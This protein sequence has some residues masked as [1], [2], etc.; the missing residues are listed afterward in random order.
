MSILFNELARAA[1]LRN[2]KL[3]GDLLDLFA[4]EPLIEWIKDFHYQDLYKIYN[5]VQTI[6]NFRTRIYDLEKNASKYRFNNT[7]MAKLNG[8]KRA[9]N[10]AVIAS[11]LK[12]ILNTNLNKPG[13]PHPLRVMAEFDMKSLRDIMTTID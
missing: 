10:P 9:T 8:S 2:D 6:L 12:R 3:F 13:T 5:D 4:G 7:T 1:R 11:R